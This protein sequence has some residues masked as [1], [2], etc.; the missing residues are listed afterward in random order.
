MARYCCYMGHR[1]HG[2]IK[3]HDDRN[4]VIV[5]RFLWSYVT[6]AVLLFILVDFLQQQRENRIN[7]SY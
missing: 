3:E 7:V 2:N 1:R 5:L 4:K 6:F